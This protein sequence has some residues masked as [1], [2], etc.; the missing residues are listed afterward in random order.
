M[1]TGDRCQVTAPDTY[2][3]SVQIAVVRNQSDVNWNVLDVISM[4]FYWS[5]SVPVHEEFGSNCAGQLRASKGISL[6][7]DVISP[8]FDDRFSLDWNIFD[9]LH[10]FLS[11]QK[12]FWCLQNRTRYDNV[13]T[14][15]IYVF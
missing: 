15:A 1:R 10:V 14:N 9:H 8:K 12:A 11:D 13:V 3:H 6:E 2:E 4:G 5:L 7:S